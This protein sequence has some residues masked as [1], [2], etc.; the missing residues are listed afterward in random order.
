[1]QFLE[2]QWRK[3]SNIK[4]E[5]TNKRKSQLALEPNYHATKHFS[6]NLKAIEIK[7]TKLKMNKP[8]YLGILRLDINK[9]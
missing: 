9:T 8:I 3:H 5:T 2:K 1:M 6:D 4:L 7:K